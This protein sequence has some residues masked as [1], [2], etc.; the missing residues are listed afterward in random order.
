MYSIFI[1]DPK[2]NTYS[3]YQAEEGVNYKGS[4]EEVKAEVINL[5]KRGTAF[6]TIVVVHNTVIDLSSITIKD[7]ENE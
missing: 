3:L 7:V 1:R 6:S 4:L 5:M 2:S